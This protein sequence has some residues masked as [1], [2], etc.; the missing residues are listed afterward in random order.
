MR[1]R[2]DGAVDARAAPYGHRRA[3]ATMTVSRAPRWIDLALRPTVVRR[4]TRV[5]LIVGTLLVAINHGEVL[6][7]GEIDALRITQM[8]LT[9]LV[10]Y[11][12]STYAAVGALREQASAGADA[13]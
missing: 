1:S 5:S 9:Y 7:H 13:S 12:V 8:L 11:G 4:A 10:P 6:L 2:N 3:P